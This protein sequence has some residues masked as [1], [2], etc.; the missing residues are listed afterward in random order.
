MN[1]PWWYLCLSNWHRRI[2]WKFL[3]DYWITQVKLT[4]YCNWQSAKNLK[5][6]RHI[7]YSWSWLYSGTIQYSFNKRWRGSISVLIQNGREMFNE[8]IE[9]HWKMCSPALLQ[10]F[11]LRWSQKSVQKYFWDLVFLSVVLFYALPF[12]KVLIWLN[13]GFSV[14]GSCTLQICTFSL[15]GKSWYIQL[16]FLTHFLWGASHHFE[17]QVLFPLSVCLLATSSVT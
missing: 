10:M 15:K 16:L 11:P 6:I 1:L 7:W 8:F 17:P 13:T 9:L 3:T 12:Q 5:T 2:S 4:H 14:P